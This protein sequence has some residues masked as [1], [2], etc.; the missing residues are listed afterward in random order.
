MYCTCIVYM[1]LGLHL[2]V[3]GDVFNALCGAVL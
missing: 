2:V 3:L 1:V